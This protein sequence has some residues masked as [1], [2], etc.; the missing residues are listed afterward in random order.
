MLQRI[1]RID[2]LVNDKD[3]W[4]NELLP[5]WGVKRKRKEIWINEESKRM[6]SEEE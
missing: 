5:I 4:S 2:E 1:W 6:T 3:H